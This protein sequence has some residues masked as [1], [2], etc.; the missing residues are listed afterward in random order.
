MAD[1]IAFA[2]RVGELLR[3]LRYDSGVRNVAQ[4]FLGDYT[5]ATSNVSLSRTG[6]VVE[7]VCYV[8]QFSKAA[9]PTGTILFTLPAGFR[10][11]QVYRLD[12]H[13]PTGVELEV[14]TDGTVKVATGSVALNA[15]CTF[16]F[17][18]PTAQA[19]PTVLPGT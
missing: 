17:M 19:P 1:R 16:R 12:M 3:P 7:F 14:G 13:R 8:R 15:Y 6:N 9:A 10:P 2:T 11:R 5:T 4:A 18:H